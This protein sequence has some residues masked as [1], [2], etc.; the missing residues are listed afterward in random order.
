[1]AYFLKAKTIFMIKYSYMA[2]FPKVINIIIINFNNFDEML[3]LLRLILEISH[4]HRPFPLKSLSRSPFLSINQLKIIIPTAVYQLTA[5]V[6]SFSLGKA[7]AFVI[8]LTPICPLCVPTT[9][10]TYRLTF[11]HLLYNPYLF[12]FLGFVFTR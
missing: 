1:M 9:D 10:L 12:C 3:L 6:C 7:A 11:T 4:T 5:P 2:N 8:N